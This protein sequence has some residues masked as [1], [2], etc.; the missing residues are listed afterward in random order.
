MPELQTIP[1]EKIRPSP[2]Q[3]REGFDK[4]LIEELAESM[5]SAD[6]L[7]PI[8]VRPHKGGFQIACGERRWRAAQHAGWD[9]IP[10]I[11]REM[12]D[13]TLQLYSLIENLHRVDL[14]APEKEKAVHDLW[15]KHYEPQRKTKGELARDI[16]VDETTVSRL[17]V[18]HGDRASF[19]SSAIRESVSTED[20]QVTRGLDEPVRRDLLAKKAKGEIAQK[21]LEDIAATAKGA[22]VERQRTIVEHVTREAHK[23][24]ELVEV[25]KEE[26]KALRSGAERVEIRVGADENRLRRLAD[27]SKDV[28]AYFTVANI[29]MIKNDAFRWKAVELIQKTREDCERVLRQL[30]S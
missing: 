30:Q 26:A 4:G 17:I 24:R 1:V 14:S 27:V 11:V 21:E 20:L 8:I 10:A 6:L 18:S 23:A 25:A 16:G 22:P 9:A 29:E 15:K 28:R 5:K 19:K 13:R 3:P 12:D 7:Q 2:F